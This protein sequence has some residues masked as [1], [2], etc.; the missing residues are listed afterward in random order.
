MDNADEAALMAA[1]AAVA[2]APPQQAM[3]DLSFYNSSAQFQKPMLGLPYNVDFGASSPAQT[4]SRPLIIP[5]STYPSSPKTPTSS[6]QQMNAPWITTSNQAPSRVNVDPFMRDYG[7]QPQIQQH[8]PH[9]Q[10]PILADPPTQNLPHQAVTVDQNSTFAFN[11]NISSSLLDGLFDSTN[12]SSTT[13][14]TTSLNMFDTHDDIRLFESPAL[15]SGDQAS[16]VDFMGLPGGIIPSG[17]EEQSNGYSSAFSRSPQLSSVQSYDFGGGPV[18]DLLPENQLSEFPQ[19]Q[20][21][22]YHPFDS[23]TLH[24]SPLIS[25][26][27]LLVS[28]E[29]AGTSTNVTPCP[30]RTPS[31]SVSSRQPKGLAIDLD[32]PVT[33]TRP[34]RNS[35]ARNAMQ[36]TP[37]ASR[38]PSVENTVNP[39]SSPVIT[40]NT[41]TKPTTRRQ[42]PSQPLPQPQPAKQQPTP[43]PQAP[44]RRSSSSSIFR[45]DPDSP[46]LS[47]TNCKTTN[48]P[49]WRRN[50]LSLKA[51]PE[52]SG[53]ITNLDPLCNACGLFYKLHGILRPI[54]MKSDVIRKRKRAKKGSRTSSSTAKGDGGAAKKS[55]KVGRQTVAAP[56]AQNAKFKSPLPST[57]SFPPSPPPSV[58]TV[59]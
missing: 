21:N 39:P 18:S 8:Q 36:K 30:W 43:K 34:T 16:I 37:P 20:I 22:M 31:P 15:G 33:R 23:T 40:A 5:S 19:H 6:H 2:A 4:N 17:V 28:P 35:S 49:L 46:P 14:T 42:Q 11:Q 29:I 3:A 54:S 50:P 55:A 12:P 56:P 52:N 51:D 53:A 27:P 57:V 59:G 41:T 38:P 48:T 10:H 47:C 25:S 7:I 9:L 13:A 24:P 58:R 1:Y 44:R 26:S 32:S 45:K